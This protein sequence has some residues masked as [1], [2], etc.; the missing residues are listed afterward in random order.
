MRFHLDDQGVMHADVEI[1]TSLT[2][3]NS[4]AETPLLALLTDLRSRQL[5]RHCGLECPLR[6]E[7]GLTLTVAYRYLDVVFPETRPVASFREND[8][9]TVVGRLQRDP[10]G[11]TLTSHQFIYAQP[12]T[13]GPT[14][15][16]ADGATAVKL[17]VPFVRITSGFAQSDRDRASFAVAE[18]ARRAVLRLPLA[19]ELIAAKGPMARAGEMGRFRIAPKTFSPL[20][21]EPA[22]FRYQP[23]VDRD[24]SSRA[25][26]DAT[27]Y[28]SIFD[29]LERELLGPRALV[30]L[31]RPLLD[32]RTVVRRQS[33]HFRDVMA[34]DE[35][36]IAADAS[37]ENPW[38]KDHHLAVNPIRL[39]LNFEVTRRA[40][41][42]RVAVST[43]EKLV[44]G[45][46]LE[47]AGLLGALAELGRAHLQRSRA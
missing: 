37:I 45:A 42:K 36:E 8:R 41:R 1:G 21:L 12:W 27:R 43:V 44:L 35:L 39:L 18:P 47:S 10:R 15:W 26:V 16:L 7:R 17:G 2:V 23:L 3:R 24:V 20:Q 29:S 14:D 40:D 38:L 11:G 34:G 32:R 33:A 31:G 13:A 22:R 25:R 5:V 46:S 28:P 19:S 4:L 9:I 6:D 30:P